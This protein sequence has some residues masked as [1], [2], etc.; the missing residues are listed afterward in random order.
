M[1][2]VMCEGPNELAVIEI[3]LDAGMLIFLRD[4]LLDLRPFHARQLGGSGTVRAAL[5]LYP[6]AVDVL[7]I[8]DTLTDRL[9][10]P[11]AYADKIASV[12]KF[13]TKPEIEML[14][15]LAEGLEAEFEKVKAGKNKRS[16]KDFSKEHIFAGRKRYDNST[17]F[18]HDYFGEQPEKLVEAIR[19]TAKS[20]GLTKRMRGILLNC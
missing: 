16:A 17:Q 8:G 11:S 14:L 15:I 4:D 6:G 1:K 2:L 10:I 9:K 5:N 19:R 3:L 13:C 20:K 18:Y 12:K 7:R